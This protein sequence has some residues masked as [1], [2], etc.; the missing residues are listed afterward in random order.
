MQSHAQRPRG[1]V[2][3]LHGSGDTGGGVRDWLSSASGGKFDRAIAELGL[4]EV[5]YPTAPERRYTLAGGAVSTVWFDRER[6]SP[7]S[8]QDRA[9]VLRSLRQVEDEVRK[10]EDAG[11]PRSGVFV[12]GFSMGG[13]LALEA[14]GAEG[15]AGRLAGVF[16]HASFL[17]DDSA[18]FEVTAGGSA[19]Q[20]SRPAPTPVYVTHGAA[21]GMVKVAWGRSTAEKLKARGGLDLTFK[22]HVEL[23]HELE[24]EQI[25][26]LL[27][28]ISTVVGRPGFGQVVGGGDGRQ[29]S[30]AR[31]GV[32]PAGATEVLHADQVEPACSVTYDITD[33]G[34]CQSRASFHVPPGRAAWQRR[35]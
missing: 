20:S 5:V 34:G 18:V 16:S 13:C 33:L 28:W 30:A 15:L 22:E 31:R 21:D 1:A 17:S 8:R 32:S 6:L 25:A 26:G 10:L 23:D 4:G 19:A 35:S 24:E 29:T 14:L 11:V 12:G 9:G 2:I 3:F 7:G 27:D